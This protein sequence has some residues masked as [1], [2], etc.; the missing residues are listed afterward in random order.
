MFDNICNGEYNTKRASPLEIASV[1]EKSS[2]TTA[3]FVHWQRSS[4][5]HGLY[6]GI[7]RYMIYL[8]VSNLITEM[9]CLGLHRPLRSSAVY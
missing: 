2:R 3:V 4:T 1:C 5:S 6:F 7:P 9:L 8:S